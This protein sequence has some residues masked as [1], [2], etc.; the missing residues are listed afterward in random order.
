MHSQAKRN[1]IICL[2]QMSSG[3][4]FSAAQKGQRGSASGYETDN[5]GKCELNRCLSTSVSLFLW[6][7]STIT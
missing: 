6:A 4:Y 5:I 7:N 1:L 2:M 3:A